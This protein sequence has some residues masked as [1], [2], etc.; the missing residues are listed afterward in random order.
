MKV[1]YVIR[2][3]GMYYAHNSRGYVSSVYMAELYDEVWAKN[4]AKQCAECR[5][6]PVTELLTS[7]EKV[8]DYI[9]R[10]E[11]MRDIMKQI[12]RTSANPNAKPSEGRA[13]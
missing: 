3:N 8:E 13:R 1:P 9:E 6:I 7:L 5:A 11:A 10:L 12:E 2:K 4:H